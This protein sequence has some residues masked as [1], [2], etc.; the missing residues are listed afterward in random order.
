MILIKILGT[1]LLVY[2]LIEEVRSG[3]YSQSGIHQP[4][5]ALVILA[6]FLPPATFLFAKIISSLFC[7]SSGSEQNEEELETQGEELKDTKK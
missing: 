5:F 6:I 3:L 2:V 7:R 4:F 1:P